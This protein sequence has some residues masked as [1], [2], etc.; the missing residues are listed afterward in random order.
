VI[1]G[2]ISYDSHIFGAISIYMVI[3]IA[4]FIYYS[5]DL[6]RIGLEYNK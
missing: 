2:D 3:G 5:H 6:K 4:D 1:A